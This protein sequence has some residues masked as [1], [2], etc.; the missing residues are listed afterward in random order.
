MAASP[1]QVVERVIETSREGRWDDL[2]D[3]FAPDAVVEI[4][5]AR[6]PEIR[7]AQGRET[8]RARYRAFGAATPYTVEQVGALTIHQTSDPEVVVAE[9]DLHLRSRATQRAAVA[10]FVMVTRVRDGLI[11][12]SR[13]YSDPL[14]LAEVAEA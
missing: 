8:L 13:D 10:S 3:L 2:A 7:R 9:Y 12:S 5:F 4:P 1:S 6:Q 14:A 11:V